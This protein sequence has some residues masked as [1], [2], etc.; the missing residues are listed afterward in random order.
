MSVYLIISENGKLRE[1]D[2]PEI[3]GI[4]RKIREGKVV[5]IEAMGQ[6]AEESLRGMGNRPKRQISLN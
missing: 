1:L 4:F 6:N 3:D 2:S 5:H